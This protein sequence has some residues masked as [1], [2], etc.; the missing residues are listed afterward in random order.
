MLR[1]QNCAVRNLSKTAIYSYR[2][3]LLDFIE[4]FLYS[5]LRLHS[6]IPGMIPAPILFGALIDRACL[7]WQQP[8]PCSDRKGACFMLPT[9]LPWDPTSSRSSSP[10][11]VSPSH[12]SSSPSS[13]TSPPRRPPTLGLPRIRP[14]PRAVLVVRGGDCW[15]DRRAKRKREGRCAVDWGR[16]FEVVRCHEV[17]RHDGE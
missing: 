3:F 9:T 2:V 1:S 10:A 17:V 6:S 5:K 4:A 15:F 12:S 13:A 16:R 8:Q 11:R 14:P 7:F